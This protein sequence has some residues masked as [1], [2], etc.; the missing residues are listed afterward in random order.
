MQV[1]AEGELLALYCGQEATDTEAVPTT[2]VITSPGNSLSLLFV[3]D[4][5][6]E[7]RYSG[8]RAHY[9]AEG[10][11]VGSARKTLIHTHTFSKPCHF[12]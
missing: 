3:S 12:G 2:Q 5:S 9:S 10:G 7:E 8:F 11:L 6:D 4:F 1:D